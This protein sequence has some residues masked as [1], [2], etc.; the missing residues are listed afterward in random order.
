MSDTVD[1]RI[2]T[3][4]AGSDAF[5]GQWTL[6]GG[7]S[8]GYDSPAGIAVDQRGSVYVADP[9]NQRVVRLWGDDTYLGELGGPA[10]LGGAELAAA[11][12]VAVSPVTDQTYVADTDHNRV[13]VY[14]PE[15][16][17]QARWGAG[18]GDGAAGSGPG[19]F[20][21]PAAVAA[22]PSGNVYV[23]DTAN[24]RVV[25]LSLSGGVIAEWGA[26]DNASGS[27]RA[28][29]GIA[30]D[31]AGRVYVADGE[32]DR[33]AVF[34]ADG[35]FLARWGL[36]GTAPGEL[37]QPTA[38][39]VGCDGDVYVADTNN[40]RVQRFALAAPA[41]PHDGAQAGGCV[42]PGAWPPPLNVAPV[43][44]VS[45][46]RTAGVLSRRAL[47]LQVSCRRGCRILVTA[48]LSAPG[49][50]RAVKLLAAA[51][52]LPPAIA[53]HVRLL[54]TPSA[55]RRLRGDLGHRTTLR[56]LVRIVAAGPTGLR[57]TLTRSYLVSR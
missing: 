20:D 56:A 55:L 45:V 11:G 43:L 44:H 46:P 54:L 4:A 24:N 51:R 22:A 47:A 28:P 7:H 42:A 3:F 34:E 48:T 16:T 39:A 31:A 40:N 50:R 2:E 8:A 38:V 33:I 53:G 52:G 29:T 49:R 35:R 19:A 12:S 1:D 17:L 15:G 18:E 23:A 32:H 30:V 36:R 9:G 37:S 21:R 26:R 27:L 41:A 25:E 57:T 6:A 13:L 14:G 10:D 5:A